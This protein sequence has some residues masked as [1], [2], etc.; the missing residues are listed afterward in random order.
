METVGVDTNVLISA[1]VGHGKPKRLVTS[2][3]KEH[4]LITSMEML[5]E[6]ADVLSR[7]KFDKVKKRQREKFLSIL[8]G[9]AD[10]VRIQEY[11]DI[12]TEDSEDNIVLST[13]SEGNANYI[14][15]GDK[16][17]LSLKQFKG[18]KIVTVNKMLEKIHEDC[19]GL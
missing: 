18:I 2:L 3:L 6:L 11:V 13:A 17:L 10:V 5:A 14:V 9:K 7:A 4:R 12:I 1:L 15:T 19:L 8:A 16:H